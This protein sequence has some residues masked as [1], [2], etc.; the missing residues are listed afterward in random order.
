MKDAQSPQ[1]KIAVISHVKA[2][3]RL[4][5]VSR[6]FIFQ[7]YISLFIPAAPFSI[8]EF[9]ISGFVFCN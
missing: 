2:K 6:G 7:F 4:T 8:S 3:P 5:Q 9:R 1:S